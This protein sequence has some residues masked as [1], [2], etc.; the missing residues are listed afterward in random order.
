MGTQ[1]PAQFHLLIYIFCVLNI[2]L[3]SSV[4]TVTGVSPSE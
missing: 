3:M 4:S 2:H 1:G